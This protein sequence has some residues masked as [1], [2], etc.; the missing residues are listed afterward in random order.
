MFHCCLSKTDRTYFSSRNYFLSRLRKKIASDAVFWK[1]IEIPRRPFQ[2]CHGREKIY[3]YFLC[4]ISK[5]TC[6]RQIISPDPKTARNMTKKKKIGSKLRKITSREEPT[7]CDKIHVSCSEVYSDLSIKTNRRSS[8]GW[9]RVS[10][11][12]PPPILTFFYGK[13]R[14]RVQNVAPLFAVELFVLRPRTYQ[15]DLV[16]LREMWAKASRIQIF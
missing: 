11:V 12:H 2:E 16:D 6:V 14:K 9:P 7:N 15:V 10:C 5:V 8:S 3:I 4:A 13:L 1:K